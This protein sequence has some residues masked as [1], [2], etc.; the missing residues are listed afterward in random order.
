M[1]PQPPRHPIRKRRAAALASVT[2]LTL[3]VSTSAGTGHLTAGVT[4]TGP[5]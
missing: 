4:G 2:V 3:A 1:Q 5:G